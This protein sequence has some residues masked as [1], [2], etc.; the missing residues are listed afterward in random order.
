MTTVE[1]WIA[2]SWER[3]KRR[4]WVLLAASG[5][6]GAATLLGGFI[7]SLAGM[8]AAGLGRW[9][10]WLVWSVAGGAALLLVLWLSTWAQAA[11]LEAAAG[12]A[13]IRECLVEGWRKTGPFAWTLSLVL[14]AGGG[15]A[16]LLF[17]PGLWLTPLLFWAPFIT[18]TE[19]TGGIAALETSWR[20]V[21][22][23][24][25]P[26]AGRLAIVAVVPFA[27]GLIPVLGFFL[28]LAAGPFTLVMLADLAEELRA[29][30]PGPAAPAPRLAWPVAVLS[31][32]FLG[33]SWFVI[34]AGIKAVGTLQEL[35]RAQL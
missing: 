11:A 19:G 14:L 2:R 6:A 8:Y 3:F 21:S 25:W 26:V 1:A 27:V 30:D 29:S 33:A 24:W 28:S 31:G 9:S 35:L 23:R 34:K 22:G 15:A 13:D 4:W 5:I 16:F 32:V 12:E 10:P 7:P 18:L 17:L 20:R